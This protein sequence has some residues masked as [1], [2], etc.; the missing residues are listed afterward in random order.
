MIMNAGDL[1]W[2]EHLKLTSQ[3]MGGDVWGA[4]QELKQVPRL[5]SIEKTRRTPPK[6]V[7][8]SVRK[9]FR[10]SF[11]AWRGARCDERWPAKLR[12]L[13]ALRQSTFF[14]KSKEELT[15]MGEI[16]AENILKPSVF[17]PK[18]LCRAVFLEAI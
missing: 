10:S 5:F 3:R 11:L 2:Q 6:S 17:K 14:V 13:T 15:K 8:I 9:A 12:E 16:R 7:R 1:M 18:T 4:Y